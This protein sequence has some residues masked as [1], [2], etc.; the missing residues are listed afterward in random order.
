MKINELRIGNYV[1]HKV[2]GTVEIMSIIQTGQV[3]IRTDRNQIFTVGI[4][5]VSPIAI[6]ENWLID[7]G[8]KAGNQNCVYSKKSNNYVAKMFFF[9][10][11]NL[12]INRKGV[13]E[14]E[15]VDFFTVHSFQN[16]IYN[17]TEVELLKK[18]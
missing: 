2:Y 18:K 14:V 4:S 10:A 16:L 5:K 8:F 13:A 6:D 11:W 15:L 17:I 1:N 7:F 12:T 3:A 9:D